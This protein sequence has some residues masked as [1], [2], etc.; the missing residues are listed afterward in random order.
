VRT[1]SAGSLLKSGLAGD[2]A[3]LPAVSR[4]A[5]KEAPDMKLGEEGRR[6]VAV[7]AISFVLACQIAPPLPGQNFGQQPQTGTQS[8]RGGMPS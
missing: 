1:A 7:F 2:T 3:S 4:R 6:L 8:R 5:G